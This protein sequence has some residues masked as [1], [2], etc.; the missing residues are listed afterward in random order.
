MT[1][2]EFFLK[3][4][5]EEFPVFLRVFKA[6][7]KDKLDYRPHARSRTAAELVWIIVLDEQ[8]ASEV[9]DT[10]KIRWQE[11]PPPVTLDE[12]M[13]AY[14][15]AHAELTPRLKKVDDKTWEEKK[16]QLLVEGQVAFEETLG[17][18]L[19]VGLFDAVHH[20]GQLST[21]I[22]PMGGTVP[23]IYGPSGDDMGA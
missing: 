4:A 9:L 16:V 15:K 18:M 3:R 5:E 12:M 10:G 6:L 13:A 2:R 8:T 22:R 7:P 23:S 17:M 21:Y 20:R 14:E 1:N 19:W 11:V